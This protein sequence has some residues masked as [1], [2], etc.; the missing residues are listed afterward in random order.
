VSTARGTVLV[1]D[2]DE[3]L[4]RAVTRLGQSVGYVVKTFASAR[5]FLD[6]GLRDRPACLVLD[7]RMAGMS[8]LELHAELR[9][10]NMH[11]PVVFITGHGD[12]PMSVRAMKAG[13]FDFLTKPFRN[14]DLLAAIQAAL[15]E[16]QQHLALGHEREAIERRLGRLTPREREVFDLLIRGRMNKE[17]AAQTG[18]SVLTVK[19]HR[20]RVMEKMEVESL[21]CL[22]QAAAKIGVLAV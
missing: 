18:T 3:S 17:I 20:A 7:V 14:Q 21:A 19:V 2:D 13:A 10:R 8:G 9:T 6:A 16:D 12:I 11:L 5:D 1:V 4:R 22:V 15:A